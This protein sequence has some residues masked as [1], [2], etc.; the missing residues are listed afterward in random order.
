MRVSLGSVSCATV[1]ILTCAALAYGQAETGKTAL[2]GR[3]VD[4]SGKSLVKRCSN[5][6]SRFETGWSSRRSMCAIRGAV[7]PALLPR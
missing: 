2:S 7:A 1:T 6:A 3:V 5:R 4:P